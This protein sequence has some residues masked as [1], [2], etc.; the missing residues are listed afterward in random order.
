MLIP[1]LSFVMLPNFLIYLFHRFAGVSYGRFMAMRCRFT[2]QRIF[3]IVGDRQE[4]FY[5]K[6]FKRRN[7]W[8]LLTDASNSVLKQSRRS[9]V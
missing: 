4:G 1:F 3:R 2:C 7:G 9:V 6:K 8:V 5:R